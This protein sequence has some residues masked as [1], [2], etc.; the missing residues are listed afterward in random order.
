[1]LV[2]YGMMHDV[3]AYEK[4]LDADL[5]WALREGSL[6]F[7]E[8]NKVHETLRRITKRLA[9]LGVPYAVVGGM[10]M[11]AP[12]TGG[13]RTMWICCDAGIDGPAAGGV[14]GA[15]LRAA[16]GDVDEAAGHHVGR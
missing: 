9:E 12:G 3:I 15:G 7:E 16:G 11:F 8:K 2:A 6:H 1:M 4:Q 10:A 14:G 13:S 5:D